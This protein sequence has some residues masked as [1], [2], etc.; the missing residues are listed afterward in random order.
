MTKLNNFWVEFAFKFA[1]KLELKSI[2]IST[3][4]ND[5]AQ[6]RVG[7]FKVHSFNDKML[8]L[9]ADGLKNG[10]ILSAAWIK[11]KLQ[12]QKLGFHPGQVG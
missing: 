7:L 12:K 4:S 9:G 2:S 1:L 6:N 5:M 10:L 8:R 3:N 11:E